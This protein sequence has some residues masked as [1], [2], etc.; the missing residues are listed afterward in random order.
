MIQ[1]GSNAIYYFGQKINIANAVLHIV[2][3]GCMAENW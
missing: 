3:T 2:K 1:G